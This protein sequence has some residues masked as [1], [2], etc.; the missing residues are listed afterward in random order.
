VLAKLALRAHGL[1]FNIALIL[2][3]APALADAISPAILLRALV[4]ESS[5]CLWLLVKGVNVDK[6]NRSI[7]P[8]EL[9]AQ[10]QPRLN[11]RRQKAHRL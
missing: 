2:F 5:F 10:I 3:G 6:W 11:A 1:A 7:A 9:I 4:G 8:S